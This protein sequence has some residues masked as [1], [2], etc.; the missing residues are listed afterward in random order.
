MNRHSQQSPE[1]TQGAD[2]CQELGDQVQQLREEIHVLWQAIDEFRDCLEHALRNSSS[3]PAPLHV[4]SL[5]LDPT[6]DDFGQ[7]VNGVPVEQV[8]V[9]RAS[10]PMPAREEPLPKPAGRQRGLF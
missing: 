2:A 8:D 9:L 1:G 7:R 10:L 3:P 5:P 6:A 4:W